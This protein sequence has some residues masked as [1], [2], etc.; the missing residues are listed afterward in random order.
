MLGGFRKI[1][2]IDESRN[3]L[4]LIY[5]ATECGIICQWSEQYDPEGP[6]YASIGKII[7]GSKIKVVDVET[8][9]D[10]GPGQEG[11]IY[12]QSP[13]FMAGYM[14]E[15]LA[16]EEL[17]E[18]DWWKMG[19]IG[20]YDDNGYLYFVSRMKDILKYRGVQLAPSELEEILLQHPAVAEACVVGKLHA[21]DGDQPAAFVVKKLNTS[22]SEKELEEFVA[23]RVPNSKRIR[24][25]VHF[26]DSIPKSA[27]GKYLS[28]SLLKLLEN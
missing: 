14:N 4:R 8:K 6:E 3:V 22:V 7:K 2:A 5:G 16:E 28:K 26:I 17:K 25:G 12:V 1:V 21:I 11:E 23:A 18:N 15:D 24:A 20:Y 9:K 13:C 19:D 27:V 10:L